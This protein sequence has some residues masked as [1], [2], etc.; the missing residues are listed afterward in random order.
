MRYFLLFLL[1]F[2][3]SY[4]FSE[5]ERDT[6]LRII[7]GLYADK[8]YN[9]TAKKCQEYLEKAPP[10]DPYREKVLK[11][12]F[13]SYFN[14]GDKQGFIGA[15]SLIEG[16]K[17]SPETAKE[18][19]SLGLKLT[20]KDPHFRAEIV[21]FYIPFTKGYEKKKMYILLANT[22]KE[23]GL[24]GDIL[25]LPDIKEINLY[26][27]VALY[28]LKRYKDLISFTEKMEQFLPEDKD[29]VLYY[30]G[31]AFFNLG[32]QEKAVALIESITFKTP[33]M[34]K[35]LSDYYLKNKNY[36]KAEKYLRILSLEKGYKDYAY[37]YLGVIEDLSKNYSKAS[38]WYRKAS[39]FD[40]KYGELARKRLSEL[41]KAGVV[42]NAEFYSVRII[43]YTDKSKAEKLIKNKNLQGCFVRKYKKF[44]AV[45][46]GKFASRNEA[47][48]KR[49]NLIKAG[50]KDAV[51]DRI[52]PEN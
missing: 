2:S 44:Y 26:K 11:L 39:V 42:K 52:S 50:F 5:K 3:L 37:Y 19:F 14:A 45:Y 49:K 28:K 33:K 16:E 10:D 46:C 23:A 31:L 43:L 38:L 18:V 9:V 48:K 51:I 36:I 34:V 13:H 1:L 29:S 22:L 40:T 30:R 25:K 15:L 41:K 20:E 32:N 12:M 47:Q 7:Q 35:F 24:W 8:V 6:L 21:R 27:V 17:I 4:G